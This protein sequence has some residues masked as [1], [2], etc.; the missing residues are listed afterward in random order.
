MPQFSYLFRDETGK[1][2]RG[3]M[4]ADS[5]AAVR[6][7]L[8]SQGE[9]LISAKSVQQSSAQT[10]FTNL[11]Q[12]LPPRSITVEV[13]LEQMA[14]MLESGL[15]ILQALQTIADQTESPAMRLV[16]E[17]LSE[18]IQDGES[19]SDAMARHACFP[20]LA[21]QLAKVGEATGNLDVT[22]QR[23]AEQMAGRREN[24]SAVRTAVS[25]PAFVGVAAIGVAAY[26]VLYVIPELEKFLSAMGRKLPAITQSL[27][28][29]SIW[30]RVNGIT[31]AAAIVA[32]IVAVVLIYNWPTGRSIIDRG[33]LRVPVIGKVFRIAGTVTFASSLGVLL[34]S[35]ITVLEALRTVEGLHVNTH[36]AACVANARDAVMEGG[37]LAQPLAEK[38][39]Y[40]PMLSSMVAV[41]ENTGQLDE[42]LERVT[43]FHEAQLK[44]AIRNLSAL[45]EPLTIV[46][47]GGIVGYVYLAFFV[48]L[49]AAGG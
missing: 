38:H 42:V 18:D 46:L 45:I 14:V 47:V 40:M 29:F 16:C 24:I 10:G 9:R 36:L 11:M 12:R 21:V 26:M 31:V 3:M 17:Q 19:V 32:S 39:T 30:I 7:T 23:A 41:G 43:V 28:D 27:L 13:A 37:N 33:M 49:F 4:V 1:V 44:A 35:G 48:A 22:L 25:Y 6:S 2:Q 15:G 20:Q 5:L 34:R 8:E